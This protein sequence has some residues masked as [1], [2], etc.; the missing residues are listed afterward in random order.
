M[1]K[2]ICSNV[3]INPNETDLCNFFIIKKSCGTYKLAKKGRKNES[4]TGKHKRGFFSNLM[5]H[6]YG[7]K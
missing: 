4:F 6:I 5:G 2:I 7:K 3:G 1:R